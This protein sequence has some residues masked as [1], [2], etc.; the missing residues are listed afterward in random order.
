MGAAPHDVDVRWARGAPAG[1]E[2]ASGIGGQGAE[3]RAPL[4]RR[5]SIDS[6][7]YAK[8]RLP[9]KVD[10]ATGCAPAEGCTPS[11]A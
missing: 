1:R 9:Q 5:T 4:A 10:G 7:V 8:Q 6:N 3:A 11:Q 2:G